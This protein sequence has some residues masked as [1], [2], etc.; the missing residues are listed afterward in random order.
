MSELNIRTNTLIKYLSEIFKELNV[1]TEILISKFNISITSI[2]LSI[3][4]SYKEHNCLKRKKKG[5]QSYYK[6]LHLHC[7]HITRNLINIIR[8]QSIFSREF[9]NFSW[10][11]FLERSIVLNAQFHLLPLFIL[12]Y[13]ILFYTIK[14]LE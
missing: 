10:K 6:K 9:N 5:T 1:L 11:L 4:W 14:S 7:E 13:F 8:T 3:Y 12:F 2:A